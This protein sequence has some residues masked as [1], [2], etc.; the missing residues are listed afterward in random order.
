M[1]DAKRRLNWW[2]VRMLFE[3]VHPG[4]AS[5]DAVFEEQVRLVRARTEDEAAAKGA[6]I[7]RREFLAYRNVANAEVEFT[8]R[9]ILDVVELLD[10]VMK[11]GVEVYYHF[12]RWEDVQQVRQSLQPGS[13]PDQ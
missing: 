4:K 3:Y 11:D 2:A 7:G 9:E 5:E 10:H 1:V 6:E 8:F 12:L 13:M